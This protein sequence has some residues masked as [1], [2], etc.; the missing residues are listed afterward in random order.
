VHVSQAGKYILANVDGEARPVTVEEYKELLTAKLTAEAPT[1]DEFRAQ[2]IDPESRRE[3][4]ENLPDGGRSALLI[5]QLQEMQP[6]DLFDV[7][8]ELGYGMEPKTRQDRAQ[9]FTYKHK[10]WLDGMPPATR[11]AIIALAR[12]FVGAGTEGLENPSMFK[13]LDVIKAGGIAA[14]RLLGEPADVLYETKE[15]LFAV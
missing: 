14:L 2:W 9:S 12:Q 7:L 5:R 11:I 3:L 15:R 4:L 6:Y 10:G 1:L 8:A 13:T